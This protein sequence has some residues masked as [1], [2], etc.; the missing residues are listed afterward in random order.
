[1]LSYNLYVPYLILIDQGA[2]KLE[3]NKCTLSPLVSY[4]IINVCSYALPSIC[5]SISN[6]MYSL[7]ICACLVYHLTMPAC[8]FSFSY[9][10]W[11]LI[12][13]P[14]LNR[15]STYAITQS[16]IDFIMPNRHISSLLFKYLMFDWIIQISLFQGS[17]VLNT[18]LLMPF[19][20]LVHFILSHQLTLV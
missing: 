19:S 10:L 15:D 12:T 14:T 16:I 4:V 6:L 7:S 2:S 8:K 11:L 18:S 5:D 17:P 9:K 13:E 1:M 20:L 3:F